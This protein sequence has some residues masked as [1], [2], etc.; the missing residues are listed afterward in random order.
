MS[1]SAPRIVFFERLEDQIRDEEQ[2]EGTDREEGTDEEEPRPSQDGGGGEQEIRVDGGYG[3]DENRSSFQPRRDVA[4]RRGCAVGRLVVDLRGEFRDGGEP[5]VLDATRLG[6]V[7]AVIAF[8]VPVSDSDDC[9]GEPDRRPTDET[10]RL[11]A[12][13]R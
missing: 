5:V 13:G 8:E 1:C 7:A 11:R 9:P 2:G 10:R 6:V 3:E 4:L 12:R